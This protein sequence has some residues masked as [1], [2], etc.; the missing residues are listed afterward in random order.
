MKRTTDEPAA[1]L[2]AGDL[3][4]AAAS[5]WPDPRIG[6]WWVTP[7]FQQ[8]QGQ[9]VCV[10]VSIAWMPGGIEDPDPRGAVEPPTE[11]I[12][13]A[14][15]RL[16]TAQLIERARR[17]VPFIRT[18]NEAAAEHA[19]RERERQERVKTETPKGAPAKRGRKPKPDAYYEHVAE[20][21]RQAV[22]L[23][24]RS[25]RPRLAVAEHFRIQPSTA[26]KHITT[27]RRKGY[28]GPAVAPGV[29]GEERDD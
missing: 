19:R 4:P 8:R 3:E 5:G 11:S 20:V 25:A 14:L 7:T 9:L 13:S 6:P 24:G 2:P 15:R 27:A 29:P 21:Y 18:L 10:A 17:T 26:A 1:L 28:L 12:A 16:P 22:T 23:G